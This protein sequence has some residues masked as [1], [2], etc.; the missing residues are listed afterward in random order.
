MMIWKI[1]DRLQNGKYIVQAELNRGG[2]GITYLATTSTDK[3]VVIKTLN[4][5]RRSQPD[6]N[7][8][9]QDFLNEALYLAKC[10]HPH[11]VQVE[12][13]ILEDGHWCTIL[14]YIEGINLGEK[15]EQQGAL[16]EFIA[17]EYIQQIGAA[18]DHVHQ[19][20]FLHRDIKPL[21]IMIRQNST[22]A[23]LIDF[24]IARDFSQ[25]LTQ[26]HTEYVSKGFAPIEQYDRRSQRGA[27]T[28]VYGIAATLYALVTGQKPES[29]IIR[30][31]HLTKYQSDSL[32]S[33]QE[34]NPKV[35]DRINNAIL[36]GMKIEP[37]LRPQSVQDWLKLLESDPIVTK[38]SQ[39]IITWSSAV[40]FDY[41]H[42]QELLSSSQWQEADQET[43][44]I[45]LRILGCETAG[46]INTEEIKK[47]PCRDLRTLNQLW[48]EYSQGKFS[49]SLQSRIWRKLDKNYEKFGEKL[50]WFVSQSWLPYSQL[51]F[52]LTAPQGHLPSW[53]RRGKLWASLAT[54]IRKC[55]L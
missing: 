2:F 21:N 39:P 1:G 27:Y 45:I 42:L 14:E 35:S 18:I 13:L 4:E 38:Q 17:L 36:I 46:K 48:T 49:F 40:G 24:G 28:D 22:E 30:D 12:E 23:V 43:A 54:K 55:G 31:R 41:S 34:L 3:K 44:D 37:E 53:G 16:T 15:I 10:C 47:I 25:N 6:F 11:I 19:Q 52:N 7:K 26:V 32:V 5:K 9:Q 29:S 33:P 50:G 51:T 8:H 20:G